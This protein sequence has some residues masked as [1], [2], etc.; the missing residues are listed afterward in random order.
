VAWDQQI[1]ERVG[2]LDFEDRLRTGG[3]PCAEA[4]ADGTVVV[5]DAGPP[6][7]GA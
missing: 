4:D 5:R 3:R 7:R 6:G 1:T 2:G